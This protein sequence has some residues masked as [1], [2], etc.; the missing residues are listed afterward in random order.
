MI[1]KVKTVK[2]S[3]N[4]KRIIANILDISVEVMYNSFNEYNA[5]VQ[6]PFSI[7]PKSVVSHKD[8][9]YQAD[10]EKRKFG[11]GTSFRYS[12]ISLIGIKNYL[13]FQENNKMESIITSEIT[14]TFI[15]NTL[16][17]FNT[18]KEINAAD[19]GLA[20]KVFH[21]FDFEV[22]RNSILSQIDTFDVNSLTG[23]EI[24]MIIWGLQKYS[25]EN[26]VIKEKLDHLVNFQMQHNYNEKSNL[27]YHRGKGFRRRFP[28]FATQVYSL[29]SISKYL[30]EFMEGN[31]A[32]YALKLE[33]CAQKLIKL[34]MSDGG[35]PWLYDVKRGS[36]VEPFEIYSVHQDSMAPMALLELA[37]LV[38]S[39]YTDVIDLSLG[40]FNQNHFGVEMID[41][42]DNVIYRS[43]RRPKKIYDK[44]YLPYKT[45]HSY[46]SEIHSDLKSFE[47]YKQCFSYH[48]GWI[49]YCWSDTSAVNSKGVYV[50]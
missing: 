2:A 12:L 17:Y 5:G 32:S 16:G 20:L 34:Q 18:V 31:N 50:Y 46:F 10:G 40:W 6:R 28:N 30:N 35:W 44:L 25:R 48:L 38:D 33:K 49:L 15:E 3:S 26:P 24:G 42:N 9:P 8:E 14:K 11:S 39:D 36:V 23:M 41:E 27:F 7:F 43:L 1:G 4:S 29:F 19:V 13:R 37:R 21:M 22:S 45:L 47:V